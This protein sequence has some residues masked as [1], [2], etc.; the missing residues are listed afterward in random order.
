MISTIKQFAASSA[1]AGVLGLAAM[2]GTAWTIAAP[3][4]A[5]TGT[6]GHS[7]TSGNKMAPEPAE[8]PAKAAQHAP[9]DAPPP[10]QVA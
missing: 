4:N 5:E 6:P 8:S 10:E 7:A 9:K 3:A 2:G 1:I